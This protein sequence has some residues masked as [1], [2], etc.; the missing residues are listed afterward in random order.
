[1]NC[2]R[3]LLARLLSFIFRIS[4]RAATDCPKLMRAAAHFCVRN[5]EML[6]CSRAL[7]FLSDE[8]LSVLTKVRLQVEA[9]C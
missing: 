1:M 4:F 9:D 7:E 3:F 8:V 5:F 6:L 2:A